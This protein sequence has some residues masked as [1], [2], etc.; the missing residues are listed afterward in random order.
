MNVSGCNV[1]SC[2]KVKIVERCAPT[3]TKKEEKKEEST[4]TMVLYLLIL[5]QFFLGAFQNNKFTISQMIA[6]SVGESRKFY[7]SPLETKFR[8]AIDILILYRLALILSNFVFNP[9]P[10]P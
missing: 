6:T 10:S 7:P 4:V 9:L 1:V 5:H 3:C 8:V 2:E